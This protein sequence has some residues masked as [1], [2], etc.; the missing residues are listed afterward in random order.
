M[1]AIL[2]WA[3]PNVKQPTFR[4]TSIGA[5]VALVVWVLASVAFAFYVANF[6]SYRRPTAPS[7]A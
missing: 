6:G 1:V 2:Y 7:P 3:T 4:W 5:L